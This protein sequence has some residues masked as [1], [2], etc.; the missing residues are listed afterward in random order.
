MKFSSI[1]LILLLVV[2]CAP[3]AS[4]FAQ[5]L[6][7]LHLGT[8]DLPTGV[9]CDMA[10][11]SLYAYVLAS[12]QDYRLYCYDLSDPASPLQLSALDLARTQSN[13]FVRDVV[14]QGDLLIIAFNGSFSLCDIRNPYAIN[15]LARIEAESLITRF[16][17]HGDQLYASANDQVMHWN[18]ANPQDPILLG[19]LAYP[20]VRLMHIYQD[21]MYLWLD[22]GSYAVY[23]VSDPLEY[24]FIGEYAPTVNG[25]LPSFFEQYLFIYANSMLNIY[26]LSDPLIP[27]FVSALPLVT[28][29]DVVSQIIMLDDHL[30]L[31]YHPNDDK[32]SAYQI[33]DIS[34]L[35]APQMVSVDIL[36][37]VWAVHGDGRGK[38]AICD[39]GEFYVL[40][41]I[42]GTSSGLITSSPYTRLTAGDVNAFM[43][44]PGGGLRAFAL[45][46]PEAG[47]V[48]QWNLP[49]TDA[50]DITGDYLVTANS[51]YDEH[52]DQYFGQ[53]FSVWDTSDPD[54]LSLVASQNVLCGSLPIAGI[55]ISG[56]MMVVTKGSLG[57]EVWDISNPANPVQSV[58]MPSTRLFYNCGVVHGNYLYCAVQ[59]IDS[60]NL[61][62]LQVWDISDPD[63][64]TFLGMLILAYNV[65]QIEIWHQRLYVMGDENTLRIY[66]ISD[67][68]QPA[69]SEMLYYGGEAPVSMRIHNN[70]LALLYSDRL[71]L[72]KPLGAMNRLPEGIFHLQ[73]HVY[74]MAFHGTN[75][76]VST[77]HYAILL[78]CS[79]AFE[80]TG[81]SSHEAAISPLQLNF[82]PNPFAASST[83][84]FILKRAGNTS[85]KLYNIRGQEVNTLL[86]GTMP[87]GK[88]SV[89]WDGRDKRGNACPAGIYLLRCITSEGSQT[90]RLIRLPG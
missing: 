3:C 13:D 61:Q 23:D 77:S 34:D 73:G 76:I 82:H 75:A 41:A 55:E 25:F 14:I 80:H 33:Y 62:L 50:M 8:F 60:G 66:D 10:S 16:A 36:E 30:A 57:M 21:T 89:L 4:A 2:M 15:E 42:S 22:R 84:S 32:L 64:L 69:F 72:Y 45:D 78:D 12:D 56:N 51:Y 85:L 68:A 40:D 88:H 74:E 70:S 7:I 1:S 27:V 49:A 26:D 54:T 48:C 67:P 47:P 81:I 29:F 35:S 20:G 52:Y 63:A 24:S 5:N 46:A 19:N 11:D 6:N 31:V 79:A 17:L 58:V 83:V 39:Q 71:A 87:A 90:K 86:D 9:V 43:Y 38:V 37:D 53:T 65:S 28:N 44:F 59:D 18:I